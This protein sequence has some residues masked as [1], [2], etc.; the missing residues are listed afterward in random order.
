MNRLL[1]AL[2]IA[3]PLVACKGDEEVEYE[4]FNAD[5]DSI[6]VEVGVESLLDPRVADI[7]SSTGEVVIGSV[8][9]D[10]GGGPVG[11]QRDPL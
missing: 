6:E 1:A 7:N 3:L 9:V 4:Q 2:A 11:R 10:P 8:E 5:A